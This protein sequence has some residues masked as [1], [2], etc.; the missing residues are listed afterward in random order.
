M[1]LF[2][3]SQDVPLVTSCYTLKL[4]ICKW[5]VTQGCYHF[6]FEIYWTDTNLEI[7]K[8]DDP[9]DYTD[10]YTD[11]YPLPEMPGTNIPIVDSVAPEPL[12]I[13]NIFLQ[14]ITCVLGLCGNGLVIW[15][16]GFK[17]KRTVNTTWFLGLAIADFVFCVFLPFTIVNVARDK[18]WLFDIHMCRALSFIL[19]LNMYVSVFLL[20]VISV[21]RCATVAFPV[22]SQNHRTV[23]VASFVVLV[24]WVSSTVLSLPSLLF[25]DIQPL[26]KKVLCIYNYK[27]SLGLPAHEMVVFMRFIVGF[28]IPFMLIV[29][30][31]SIIAWKLKR[32][33]LAKSSRPL[34]IMVSIIVA[35]FI[36]WVP[37]HGVH[38]LEM[39]F[40]DERPV[41]CT[42]LVSVAFN[43]ASAN[44]FLNPILYVFM[45]SEFQGIL[46]Q[47]IFFR[48]KKA[49]AEDSQIT[50]RSSM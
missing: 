6:Q 8:M 14:T 39:Y 50:A 1:L 21:D 48:L 32:R 9:A 27:N 29:L 20:T 18:D 46:R 49:L 30:C 26:H 4:K 41:T 11:D 23:R 22:W 40:C 17:M 24:A 15:I 35:F 37:F 13:I 34:K 43:V 47:S 45:G 44:S 31:Y 42:I 12:K 36:C 10:G 28:L 33:N 19:L 7:T 2:I 25:R 38:I 5:H 3:N 16:T